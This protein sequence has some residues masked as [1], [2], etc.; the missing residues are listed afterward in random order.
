MYQH[1]LHQYSSLICSHCEQ[2]I[3]LITLVS[4]ADWRN[5]T[6]LLWLIFSLTVNKCWPAH[7][8]ALSVKVPKSNTWQY[9]ATYKW[10]H[11]YYS[12][13][14]YFREV[15]CIWGV[16][17]IHRNKILTYFF[18]ACFW[19]TQECDCQYCVLCNLY[20]YTF[21]LMIY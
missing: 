9:S 21:L 20:V 1:I 3:F 14:P 8:T 19:M 15:L 11:L 6:M 2:P 10:I 16:R 5:C 4:R 12:F 17:V 7:I 13:L 18:K